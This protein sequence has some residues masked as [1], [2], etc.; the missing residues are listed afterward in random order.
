MANQLVQYGAVA[1]GAVAIP[2]I[3]KGVS[4]ATDAYKAFNTLNAGTDTMGAM[5]AAAD[6]GTAAA[7]S[8]LN[9]MASPAFLTSVGIGVAGLLLGS[10][11]KRPALSLPNLAATA[12]VGLSVGNMLKQGQ[13]AAAAKDQRNTPGG[14]L[15]RPANYLTTQ[16][17]DPNVKIATER[18]FGETLKL[19]F[20]HNRNEQYW[21]RFAIRKYDRNVAMSGNSQTPS[22]FHTM[23]TLPLPANLV[24]AMKLLYHD[25]AL[26]ALGGE[27]YKGLA[28]AVDS[29]NGASGSIAQK[30][31]AGTNSFVGSM[32]NLMKD[33]GFAQ[34]LARRAL[35]NTTLG[36][37]FDMISG[38]IPNPHMAVTFQ[39]VNLKKHQFT[40][41]LSPDNL[42]ESKTLQMI[43]RQL[44]AAALPG[45]ENN[46]ALM[47]TFPDVVTVTMSPS[48]LMTFMP[49]SIDSIGVNYAPN[50]VPSFFTGAGGQ[51][52]GSGEGQ[53]FERYPTEVEFTITLKELDVH[54]N[55]LPFYMEARSGQLATV[56]QQDGTFYNEN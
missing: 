35:T 5:T 11:S 18:S 31:G 37:A 6:A 33:E 50:G 32:A 40:W 17:S 38:N 45:Q 43:I 9:T 51:S 28:G 14:L 25:L 7:S 8:A 42:A 48:N 21:I 54:T 19:A 36:S 41:R 53:T 23:V 2:A 44:Q 16:A 29:F 49:C 34:V 20:P 24:D 47:L 3:A 1:A 13:A 56:K 30:L 46:T 52:S 55:A 22:N 39:G 4:A 10:G 12:A 26:G 15:T 27:A